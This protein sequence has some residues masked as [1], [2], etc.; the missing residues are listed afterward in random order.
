MCCLTKDEASA[1]P[2]LGLG[3]K[4]AL[5]SIN[6][7]SERDLGALTRELWAGMDGADVLIVAL[8][9]NA[10]LRASGRVPLYE[11][12]GPGGP[13]LPAPERGSSSPAVTKKFAERIPL[14]PR[15][16]RR[17]RPPPPGR[18]SFPRRAPP[19]RSTTQSPP[20][21][22]A[23]PQRGRRPTLRRSH[24]AL[25]GPS[26]LAF[27]RPAGVVA[28]PRLPELVGPALVFLSPALCV[29]PLSPVAFFVPAVGHAAPPLPR[30]PA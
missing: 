22:G 9:L 20:R 27:F 29:L 5:R 19:A 23:P 24:P 4:R 25:L 1:E 16:G 26:L 8:H 12:D 28:S 30:W 21:R 6:A 7:T 2:A 13:C 10:Q 11:R 18:A 15:R 17:T 14:P 3:V